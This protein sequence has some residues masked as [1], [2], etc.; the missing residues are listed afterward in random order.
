MKK[1]AKIILCAVLAVLIVGCGVGYAFL[2][3]PLSYPIGRIKEAGSTL[4]VLE[5]SED[6]VTVCKEGEGDFKILMFTDMHLDGKNKTSKLTVS[7]LVENIT[8][9]K[10][11]LVL[12]GGDN[13]TSGLNRVRAK[14]LGKI[15]EKLG[16][17]WAGVI[18][19]H[20]GDNK[21]S[22]S[23]TEMVDIFASFPHCLMRR[24]LD[25]VTG[26]CNY[27]LYIENEDGTLLKAF[28][29][30]DSFDEMTDAQKEESGWT[31][32]MSD[33]DG[34]KADQIAWYSAKTAQAK[35][36]Y[37]ENH[38]ILLLHIPLLQMRQAALPKGGFSPENPG[39]K[40]LEFGAQR[41]NVCCTGFENGLF[42]AVKA[43]EAQ[44][45]F[46]G[47]DHLNNFGVNVDG[48]L[49]SY[50][51]MSGYGSYSMYSKGFPQEEW[52]QGYTRLILL[53]DSTFTQ[54]QITNEGL[55][56]GWYND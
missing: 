48:V 9:E 26:D 25:S 36:T 24:G 11:D 3:H 27:A 12:L 40:G 15:F 34:P 6:S 28:Y 20:E 31:E 53:S 1:T 18:G 43:A 17:Y 54:T 22:I 39:T 33:Y 46:C 50:I 2:P 7:H 30:L 21:W 5:E 32:D 55:K 8:A 35:E 29:F 13:V 44:A 41:E 23:R 52:L 14:Q 16:V 10:P 56:N 37:G 38:S 42:A 45:V 51:E 19:N 49:L 4:K 47:H